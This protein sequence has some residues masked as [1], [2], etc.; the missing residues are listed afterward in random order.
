MNE[1]KN[2]K[3]MKITTVIKSK[4]T[5]MLKPTQKLRIIFYTAI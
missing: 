5:I 4:K 2:N 1:I 3:L